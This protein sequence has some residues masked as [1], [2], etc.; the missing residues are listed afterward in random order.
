MGLWYKFLHMNKGVFLKKLFSFDEVYATC[1]RPYDSAGTLLRD[2]E[3][4]FQALYGTGQFWY[5]DPVLFRKNGVSYLFTEAFDCKERIGRIACS[6]L[7]VPFSAPKII[8]KE[9]FHLSFPRVFS[10]ND[11]VYMLPET[12]ADRSIRLYRAS[13]FPDQWDLV[14][15]FPVAYNY[16]D[17]VVTDVMDDRIILL[18]SEVDESRQYMYRYHRL[19]LSTENGTY[20]LSHDKEFLDAQS[21]DHLSRNAGA[22]FL[23][24][25]RII[26]PTQESTDVSYG[27]NLRFCEYD[28]SSY[29]VTASPIQTVTPD[30]IRI[31]GCSRPIGIHSYSRDEAFEVIDIRYLKFDPLLYYK[32]LTAHRRHDNASGD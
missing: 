16:V 27:V 5:A 12:G 31:H 24:D 14:C 11:T 7:E 23:E 6:R 29:D 20:A 4:P 19:F 17:I 21:F 28:A 25:G 2:K 10:W 32:R 18:V 30:D 26:L 13:S 8:L 9:P 22:L 15:R 3:R 1:I